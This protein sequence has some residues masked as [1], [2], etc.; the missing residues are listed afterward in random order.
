MA[1]SGS[2]YVY[3]IENTE[4]QAYKIGITHNSV[5]KRLRQ[6]QTGSP[7]KLEIRGVFKTTYPYRLENILH[8]K[9]AYLNTMGEW[10]ELP[11][12]DVINFQQICKGVD[13]MIH[14]MKDNIFF[15]KGLC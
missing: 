10:Y 12:Q 5:E 6:L 8:R 3:L 2:G 1:R 7:A 4:M 9:Y 11:Y 15:A 14:V 13:D